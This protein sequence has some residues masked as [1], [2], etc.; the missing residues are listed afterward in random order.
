MF[1]TTSRKRLFGFTNVLVCCLFSAVVFGQVSEGNQEIQIQEVPSEAEKKSELTLSEQELLLHLSQQ[2]EEA[3]D[4]FEDPQTQSRS[5]DFFSQIIDF[6]NNE[7]RTK[8]KVA[9]EILAVQE[10][11]LELR[12]SA[13]FTAGQTQGAADDFRQLLLDNPRYSMNTE[14]LSPR[15]V[16]FFEDQKKQ[17]VGYI[18]VTTEP[19]GARVDV[20]GEFIG[21]TNFFPVEIHTG[22]ARVSVA[23]EGHDSYMNEELRITPG[24]ITTLDLVL[25]RTSALLPIITAP[26]GVEVLV[27]GEVVG[28]TT[29]TLPPDLH[30]FTPANM[31]PN[32][33]SF[34]L[35]LN[36]LSLGPHQIELR[37]DCYRPVRYPFVADFPRDYTA[38]IIKL[39]ESVGQLVVNSEPNDASVYLDGEFQ[40]MTPLEMKRVCSGT[41]RLE[42]RHPAG[43]YVKDFKIGPDQSLELDGLIRPTLAVLGLSS[44]EGVTEGQLEEVSQRLTTELHNGVDGMNLVFVSDSTLEKH[45]GKEELS[46]FVRLLISNGDMGGRVRELSQKLGDV[47]NVEALL[48]SYIPR[49]R[50]IKDVDIYFLAVGSTSPDSYRINSLDPKAFEAFVRGLSFSA[51]LYG[52]WAGFVSVDTRT[53]P[54]PVVLL[55]EEDGPAALA[56]IELG[57]VIVSAGGKPSM[58]VLDLLKSIRLLTPGSVLELNI[59]RGNSSMDVTLDIGTTLLEIP[60]DV[61]AFPCNKAIVDLRHLIVLEPDNEHIARLNA[62]LC[63]MQLGD[64]E[65]ALKE[66]LPKVS[67]TSERGISSGTIFYYTGLAYLMIGEEDE[68]VYNFK[69]ALNFPAATI[70]SNDGPR[71]APLAKRR[72]SELGH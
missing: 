46:A 3:S 39:E 29:G 68:A 56:G 70:R 9:E 19:A 20:N 42:V 38:Q 23:L 55:V 4:L 18:A 63:H 12:A 2:F 59:L 69:Q 17:L 24:E 21:I 26:S 28:V 31:D 10:H 14:T 22:L 49:Q 13:Y 35:E 40:G 33:L 6:V 16:D 8:G 37:L 41:H 47:L 43:K 15:I 71:I 65:T 27:D 11:A 57:D 32:R 60:Y 36:A 67:L 72:L 44:D 45:I 64:Y 5:I 54:G 25:N 7:W 30:S 66:Y 48:V 53:N 50:L 52:N 62:G 34:P 61:P 58:G 1:T 51:P